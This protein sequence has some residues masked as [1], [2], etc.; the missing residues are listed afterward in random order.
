[1]GQG[2][3][4][5]VTGALTCDELLQVHLRPLR[6]LHM[7]HQEPWGWGVGAGLAPAQLGPCEQGVRQGAHL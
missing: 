6:G 2:A 3:S 7:Q 5:C 1:M 4:K